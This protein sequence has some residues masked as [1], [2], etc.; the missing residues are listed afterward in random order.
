MRTAK[1]ADLNQAWESS[2]TPPTGAVL[3]YVPKKPACYFSN[4]VLGS[5]DFIA[6]IFFEKEYLDG[7]P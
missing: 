6:F 7:Q 3:A 2:L 4:F 5:S 1:G